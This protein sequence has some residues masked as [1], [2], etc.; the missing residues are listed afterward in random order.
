MPECFPSLG[1]RCRFAGITEHNGILGE[2]GQGRTQRTPKR[3]QRR[4]HLAICRCRAAACGAPSFFA[5]RPDGLW[6]AEALH[7]KQKCFFCKWLNGYPA[8]EL[9]RA[10]SFVSSLIKHLSFG[11]YITQK[12][13]ARFQA[14]T[15]HLRRTH[16]QIEREGG[17]QFLPNRDGQVRAVPLVGY[18]HH[19]VHIGI[20][21]RPTVG[22][23]TEEDYLFRL[24]LLRNSARVRTYGVRMNHVKLIP[25][26]AFFFKD[27]SKIAGIFS[28]G[29]R[30]PCRQRP[31]DI[32]T[33]QEN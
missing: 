28:T 4:M 21:R 32:F 18:D 16:Q 23:G 26:S 29:W 8:A 15:N 20:L 10:G 11:H 14:P 9:N 33:M 27:K 6:Q 19:Q 5:W 31:A 3:F 30:P 1:A 22:V 7:R 12:I 17:G 25:K 13:V 2:N 24:E